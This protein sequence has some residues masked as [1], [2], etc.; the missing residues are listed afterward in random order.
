MVVVRPF[1]V[2]APSGARL[3]GMLT[4]PVLRPRPMPAV[5]FIPGATG[6][7]RMRALRRDARALAARGVMVVG[8]NAQGRSNGRIWDVRSGGQPNLN[9][10]QDQDGLAAV[11]TAIAQRPDVD[12]SRLGI[13]SVSF[14]LAVALGALARH[15]ELPVRFLIDEEGPSDRFSAA[16]QAW[17]LAPS[18]GAHWPARAMELFG[19]PCTDDDFWMPREPIRHIAS[20]NGHYLR[21]QAQFDHVQPPADVGQVARFTQPPQWWPNKHAIDMVNAAIQADVP[22]VQFNPARCKNPTNTRWSIDRPPA[23]L[24][25]KMTDHPSVWLEA[26]TEVLEVIQRCG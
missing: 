4:R 22:W 6:A 15:P 19:H 8:F 1:T 20:F 23:Y 12:R 3:H 26:V 18:T 17:T 10:A 24:A 5:I 21:L 13:Y 9:G 25:G 14:G 11:I 16:L 2:R 7:G